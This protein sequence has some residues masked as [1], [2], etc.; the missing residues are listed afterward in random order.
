MAPMVATADEADAFVDRCAAHGLP[1]AGIMVEVPAA[2][3][4][5]ADLLDRAR[6]ASLGTNDLTQYAMAAD[7]ELAGLARLSTPWQPA[8]LSLVAARVRGRSGHGTGPSGSAA[9]P[10]PTRRSHPC[11]SGSA[12]RRCR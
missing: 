11:W 2:A 3:L 12:S 10:R 1:H 9:R 6:F 8:V 7:R 5:A 4:R